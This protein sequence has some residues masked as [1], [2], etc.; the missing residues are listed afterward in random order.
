MSAI[1]ISDCDSKFF[2][3]FWFIFLKKLKVE[4]FYLIVYYPQTNS[5]SKTINQ[6]V[7]IVL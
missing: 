3:K 4:L 2:S 5:S 1:I 7:K 6:I